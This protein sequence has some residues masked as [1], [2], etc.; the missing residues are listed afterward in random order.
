MRDSGRPFAAEVEGAYIPLPALRRHD[1]AGARFPNL[2]RGPDEVLRLKDHHTDW[3]IHR[4]IVRDHGIALFGPPPAMVIDP[5]MP[6][7]IRAATA[8]VLRS[9]WAAPEGIASVRAA[10][11]A[12]LAYVVLTMCRAA[13]SLATGQ[14]TTKPA[15][16]AWMLEHGPARWRP[17]VRK[18]LTGAVDAA[19][20]E[21]VVGFIQAIAG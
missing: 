7:D 21:D 4:A 11:P 5:V 6:D 17:L 10:P 19:R 14:V 9:W 3:V 2:E 15:A 18:A 13:Y 8:A 16:A 12:Y 1:P 20:R